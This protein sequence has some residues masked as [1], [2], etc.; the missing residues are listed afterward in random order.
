MDELDTDSSIDDNLSRVEMILTTQD[1]GLS[2]EGL[3]YFDYDEYDNSEGNLDPEIIN[4]MK[5]LRRIYISCHQIGIVVPDVNYGNLGYDKSGVL[6][7]FDVQDRKAM[8]N[9][10]NNFSSVR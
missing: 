4:F 5:E 3:T 9:N 10:K 2:Y 7:L 6:T 1:L 8:G